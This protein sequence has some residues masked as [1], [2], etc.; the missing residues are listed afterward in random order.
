[1]IRN[2]RKNVSVW[3]DSTQ[4][5]KKSNFSAIHW[6]NTKPGIKGIMHFNKTKVKKPRIA[7]K[8]GIQYEILL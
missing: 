4:M 3:K 6:I 7:F 2:R 1:M 5:K 8:G